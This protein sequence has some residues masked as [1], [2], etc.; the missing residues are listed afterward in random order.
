MCLNVFP[1]CRENQRKRSCWGWWFDRID[2]RQHCICGV[3]E[4][5]TDKCRSAE[6][7]EPRWGLCNSTS[8]SLINMHTQKVR[9]IL[10]LISLIGFLNISSVRSL[11]RAQT[12]HTDFTECWRVWHV[13]N[14]ITSAVSSLRLPAK[15]D[16]CVLV[17]AGRNRS[18]IC[19]GSECPLPPLS[20]LVSSVG[21]S[22]RTERRSLSLP[23]S[24]PFRPRASPGDGTDRLREVT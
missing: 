15:L 20:R 7:K 14:G 16:R 19:D 17:S 2:I 8:C 6:K 4:S 21:S 10:T 3:G 22:E 5:W 12:S 23:L 18:L 1:H 11:Q 13:I 24:Q 9:V